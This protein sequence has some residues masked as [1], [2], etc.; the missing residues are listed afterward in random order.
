MLG[1]LHVGNCQIVRNT[2]LAQASKN[3]FVD[4]PV[5]FD[6]FLQDSKLYP[7]LFQIQCRLLLF[8]GLSLDGLFLCPASKIVFLNPTHYVIDFNV[9][10]PSRFGHLL[11][12]FHD[13]RMVRLEDGRKL[14][15]LVF[16]SKE[17]RPMR[18]NQALTQNLREIL[19]RFV[20]Y[21]SVKG[22]SFESLAARDS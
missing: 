3:A 13:T 22:F 21:H 17:I 2:S 12:Q 6:F 19:C 20:F 8:L 7:H 5:Y 9:E 18:G 10:S 11:S 4:S 1:Y 16:E 14:Y 15:L